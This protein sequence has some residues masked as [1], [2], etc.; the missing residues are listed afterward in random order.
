LGDNNNYWV[1]WGGHCSNE[2]LKVKKRHYQLNDNLKRLYGLFPTLI[3]CCDIP[4][5][6]QQ[7]W[8]CCF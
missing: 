7:T 8:F 6:D 5:S 4:K 2:N 1:V 3:V